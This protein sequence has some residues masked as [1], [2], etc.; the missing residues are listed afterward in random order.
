MVRGPIY[1]VPIACPRCKEEIEILNAW[2]E[3]EYASKFDEQK[4]ED[5]GTVT[6]EV[7]LSDTLQGYTR[8]TVFLDHTC[9]NLKE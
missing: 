3:A 2:V 9:E 5:K 4:K 6:V 8:D 1:K 7:K